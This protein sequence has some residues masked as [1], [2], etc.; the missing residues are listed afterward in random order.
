MRRMSASICSG[1]GINWKRKLHLCDKKWSGS[2]MWDDVTWWL[3]PTLWRVHRKDIQTQRSFTI[4][5]PPLTLFL[6]PSPHLPHLWSSSLHSHGT[7]DWKMASWML[8]KWAMNHVCTWTSPDAFDMHV[9]P[10]S[11]NVLPWYLLQ[12]LSP[13]SCLPHWVLPSIFKFISAEHRTFTVKCFICKLKWKIGTNCGFQSEKV[14]FS[15]R[16]KIKINW[17]LETKRIL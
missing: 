8:F 12:P 17:S 9:W 6:I 10:L 7:V 16:F 15:L 11:G 14:I 4:F 13:P 1:W 2:G 5:C 3:F